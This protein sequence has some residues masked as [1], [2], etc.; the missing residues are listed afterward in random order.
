VPIGEDRGSQI[1][2]SM[3]QFRPCT[4][5][6]PRWFATGSGYHP[7]TFRGHWWL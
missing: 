3:I 7:R 4:P 5:F 1:R 6:P 2:V